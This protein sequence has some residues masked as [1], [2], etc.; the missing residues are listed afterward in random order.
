MKTVLT[1]T[2][3]R[4]AA[5]AIALAAIIVLSSVL[6]GP[7]KAADSTWYVSPS[8]TDDGSHG[9][10][11]GAAAF[12]TIQFAINDARLIGGDTINV[13][14]GTYVETGQIV[15]SKALSIAGAGASTTIIKPS[16]D[17]GSSGDAR[18]WFLVNDGITFSLRDVTLDGLGHKIYQAIRHLG[19]GAITDCVFKNIKYGTYLGMGIAV[20]G[21]GNVDVT[22]CEFSAIE[23]IGVIY[24]GTGV[25][26]ST[27]KW[28]KY[29][30]KGVGDWL[31]YGVEVGAG[32]HA[33]INSNTIS[34]NLGVA[35][36]DNS[37]SAGILV[38]TYYGAGTQASIT[39]NTISGCTEAIAVGYD[40]SDTSLVTAHNNNLAGNGNGIGSTAPDVDAENNWWGDASGPQ[41][42]T[43]P[44]GTGVPVSDH[45]DFTPWL[46]TPWPSEV[47]VSTTGDDSNLG[48]QTEPF[49]TIQKGVDA[50]PSGGTVHVAAGSYAEKIAIN[51][52]LTLAGDPGD[53]SAGP[54]LNA[55]VLDGSTLGPNVG[56]IKIMGGVSHL[57]VEGFE[58]RNYGTS[59]GAN[60]DEN[61]V[62]CWPY[63][64][65]SPS[66]TTSDVQ[67]RDNYIHHVGYAGV[68]TGNGWGSRTDTQGVH[69][70]WVVARNIIE[71]FGAYAVDLE[72][73]GNSQITD[74]VISGG[75]TYGINVIALTTVDSGAITVS[76][77]TV[78]GNQFNDW[79]VT[80]GYAAVNM[81]AWI[82]NGATSATSTVRSITVT[83]NTIT[84]SSRAIIA[85]GSIGLGTT[86]TVTVRDLT[87]TD[88][89]INVNNPS[90]VG[91]AVD[92]RDV[93]GTS[94]LDG[95]EITVTGTIGS[96]GTYFHGVGV[97]G[98]STGT[99]SIVNNQLNGNNVGADSVGILLKDTLPASA[100]LNIESNTITEFAKGIRSDA[101]ASGTTVTVHLN[102]IAGNSAYGIDN[103]AGAL[104]D[105]ESNWWGSATGPTHSSN[106]GGTGDTVSDNVD[107]TPWLGGESTTETV[108][109]GVVDAT[110]TADSTVGVTGTA[111]VTV[112]KYAEN[113]GGAPA[114][115]ALGSYVDVHVNDA[116]GATE[117]T[118]Q[119]YYT[120][121]DVVGHVESALK[122]YWWTG[123][124]WVVCSDSGVTYPAGEPTYRGYIWAKIRSD[125]TPNLN[126]LAGTPFGG[127]GP[128]QG[129]LRLWQEGTAVQATISLD[130]TVRDD[131]GLNWVK[132]SAG[133]YVLSFSNVPGWKNP[134]QVRVLVYAYGSLTPESDTTVNYL[135]DPIPIYANKVTEVRASFTQLGYLHVIT[136]PAVSGTIYINGV[137]VNDW[138]CWVPL[139]A[140]SYTVSFGDVPGYMKP[141]D[142]VVTVVAGTT[143]T[144]TGDYT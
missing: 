39:G 11:P 71:N 108:T 143:W 24:F 124:A 117:I 28:N 141:A 109:N 137:P 54:G 118:I 95:N 96:G 62:T 103:G 92:L 119:V 133:N 106:S 97:R 15:I 99:W 25:T 55:P 67:I 107:F 18:G 29:T 64:S 33:T 31:D 36:V 68:L 126:E 66:V 77:V 60:T 59:G 140:G 75:T 5:L 37:T 120:A 32:A 3:A 4:K 22:N 138:G 73:A 20:M 9:A 82:D 58:I 49:A 43:N 128:S 57:V 53:S 30:G 52:G 89:V 41:H 6:V 134:T 78:S 23:R 87:I 144:I 85:W 90:G 21:T 42:V 115:S 116:S 19:A 12:K 104:I 7:L 17:T 47:W 123:S 38:T 81:F 111:T 88:N 74:N 26:G 35:A 65:S 61:G 122:L 129:M 136:N 70:G 84:G 45:V 121:A 142:Q 76:G 83:G 91:Y 8:G 100:V 56:A 130:G 72:N 10:G 125:T 93:A 114:F 46:A 105:A 80:Q 110:A 51:K 112:A 16:S 14:A 132:L 48:T 44:T 1:G 135:V 13:A 98:G 63:L 94:T 113:P 79:G 139:A 86:G 131:W 50:V 40:A 127:G 2:N 101:F 102:N 69:D 34:N 27:F